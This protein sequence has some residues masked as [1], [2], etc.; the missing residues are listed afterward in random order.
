MAGLAVVL[1]SG[2]VW[3]PGPGHLLAA[4]ASLPVAMQAYL[5]PRAA[6]VSALAATLLLLV[7][8]VQEAAIFALATAPLGLGV[9]YA[10]RQPVPRWLAVALAALPLLAGLLT[11][12]HV[13]GLPPLGPWFARRGMVMETVL[14][15]LFALAY[16]GLWVWAFDR[17]VR[18]VWPG[19]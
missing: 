8:H 11:L 10:R 13:V 15:G 12:A 19:G 17:F 18:R 5:R 3:W 2:P 16:S 4:L 6:P 9:G 7:V 14:Y 1:Q